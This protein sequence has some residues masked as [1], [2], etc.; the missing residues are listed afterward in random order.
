MLYYLNGVTGIFRWAIEYGKTDVLAM[1]KQ[2]TALPEFFHNQIIK[3]KDW[4]DFAAMGGRVTALDWMWDNGWREAG[5]SHTIYYDTAKS[6]ED[7]GGGVAGLLWLFHS[8]WL[9]M[10]VQ[11]LGYHAS[12]HVKLEVLQ[13]LHKN[14]LAPW[15]DNFNSPI[16]IAEKKGYEHIAKWARENGCP[17]CWLDE[18]EDDASLF[19]DSY[20]E[21]DED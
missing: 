15:E 5:N 21:D 6:P 8:T 16:R 4:L 19:G 20:L 18:W 2:M 13:W 9:R 1:M 12:K 10:E 7:G 11:H 3:W 14:N 17:E